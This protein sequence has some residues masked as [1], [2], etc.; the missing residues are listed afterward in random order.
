M[1]DE[2]KDLYVQ[3]GLELLVRQREGWDKSTS[4]AQRHEL[5]RKHNAQLNALRANHGLSTDRFEGEYEPLK[6]ILASGRP[7]EVKP[8]DWSRTHCE[9]GEAI[10][11]ACPDLQS[12]EGRE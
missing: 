11:A 2:G 10:L 8:F 4:D 12:K 3:E 9:R 1:S 6:H 5:R 7:V